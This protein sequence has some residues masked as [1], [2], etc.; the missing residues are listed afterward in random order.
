VVDLVA[1]AATE[2]TTS[3]AGPTGNTS[4]AFPT[5]RIMSGMSLSLDVEVL[6]KAVRDYQPE[7]GIVLGSGLGMLVD[8]VDAILSLPYEEISGM[9]ASTVPGHVGRFVFGKLAGCRV[10]MA[11]GRVHLYEGRTAEEVTAAVRFMENLGVRKLLLTNAAGTLNADFAPGSWMML[12]DHLNLTGTSPL[13]GGPNFVDM[14]AVYSPELR[15][16]FAEAALAEGVN[17]HEGVYAG[18]VGPQYETPA[19]VRMLRVLGADAVGMSTVLEAIQA[20]ALKME[21]AGFSCLTNWAAGLSPQT[22]SHAE[23]LETGKAAAARMLKV[24]T[25]AFGG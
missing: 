21:V 4:P 7:W 11:Q 22:L 9:P 17:L 23:V 10:I 20:R 3:A 18:L 16:Q 25:R 15:G 24:L 2:S 8:E 12:S 13:L 1:P 6:P 14:S 19:E 5:S